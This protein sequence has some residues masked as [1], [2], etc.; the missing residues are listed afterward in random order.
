MNPGVI[1]DAAPANRWGYSCHGWLCCRNDALTDMKSAK[2]L[3]IRS[4]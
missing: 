4:L 3:C 2:L 1:G